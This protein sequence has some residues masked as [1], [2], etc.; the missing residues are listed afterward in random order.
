MAEHRAGVHDP[1]PGARELAAPIVIGLLPAL[2]LY[3]RPYLRPSTTR[4][5]AERAAE[6]LTT[7]GAGV[8]R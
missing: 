7:I 3:L 4:L 2:Q 5:S 6:A 8:K 1:R